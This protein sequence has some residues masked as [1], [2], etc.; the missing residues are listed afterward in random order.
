M[1]N[2]YNFN[3]VFSPLFP[4]C[5]RLVCWKVGENNK[6]KKTETHTFSFIKSFNAFWQRINCAVILG[7]SIL[8][9]FI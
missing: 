4:S 2:R 7:K 9:D 5:F 6:K 8:D 3:Y 1:D